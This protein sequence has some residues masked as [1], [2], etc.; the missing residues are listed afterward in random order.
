MLGGIKIYIASPEDTIANKLLFGSEQD[1]LDAMS[2][3]VRQM[4]KLDMDYLGEVCREMG[5]L[6]ELQKLRRRVEETL[7][8]GDH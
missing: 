5:V 4:G 1:I 3:Y 6:D 7:R 2:I 8:E